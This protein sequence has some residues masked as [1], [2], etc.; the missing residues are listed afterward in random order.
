MNYSFEKSR[1]PVLREPNTNSQEDVFGGK[2]LLIIILVGLLVL[3]FL[4]INLLLIL[5]DLV[6]VIAKIFSPLVSQILSVFG[7]TTGTVIDKSEDVVTSVAKT[8]IDIAGGTIDSLADLLKNISK[9]NVD[10]SARSE[11]DNTLGTKGSLDLKKMLNQPEPDNSTTIQK[12]ITSDKA[13]WCLVGEYEGKRGCVQVKDAG[14]CL[15]GQIFP[16][17]QSCMNPS[18]AGVI[19]HSAAAV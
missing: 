8:G 3:S 13:K 17:L 1:T 7:Y 14:K 5:G 16:T 18:K 15:S 11:L 6:Q 12:P 10:P 19:M 9:D 2:N 4:G